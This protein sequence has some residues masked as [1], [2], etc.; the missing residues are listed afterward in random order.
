MKFATGGHDGPCQARGKSESSAGDWPM[1]LRWVMVERAL[2]GALALGHSI[3]V[4]TAMGLRLT[5]IP[6]AD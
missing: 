4:Y 3:R 6:R 2:S 5:A 1:L